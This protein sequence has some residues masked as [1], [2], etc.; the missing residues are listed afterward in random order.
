MAIGFTSIMNS[1]ITINDYSSYSV[2]SFYFF[3]SRRRSRPRLTCPCHFEQ[4][5]FISINVSLNYPSSALDAYSYFTFSLHFPPSS[6]CVNCKGS[7]TVS[8]KM[9]HYYHTMMFTQ[10]TPPICKMIHSSGN[11]TVRKKHKSLH[12][13]T[14]QSPQKKSCVNQL[15]LRHKM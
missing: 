3:S 2:S 14:N 15:T 8:G 10:I 6:G 1:K 7:Q 5:Q 4:G 11:N 12:E 13:L 9:S